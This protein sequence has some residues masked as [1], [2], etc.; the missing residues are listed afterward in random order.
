MHALQNNIPNTGSDAHARDRTA[1]QSAISQDL[2]SKLNV[3]EILGDRADAA[4][5]K[6]LA[7]LAYTRLLDIYRRH[8]Y[9]VGSLIRSLLIKMA[10]FYW[11]SDQPLRAEMCWWDVFD[12]RDPPDQAHGI[13]REVWESLAKSLSETSGVICEV[14]RAKL[15]GF[16]PSLNLETPFPPV[17]RMV[18]GNHGLSTTDSLFR[19]NPSSNITSS[20]NT[21]NASPGNVG[22]IEKTIQELP[23]MALDT[24]DIF[25]RTPLFLAAFLKHEVAG[26]ALVKRIATCSSKPPHIHINARDFSGQT[27]LGIAI[28]SRCSFKF[29]KAL[30]DNGAEVNPGLTEGPYTPLQAACITGDLEITNILLDSGADINHVYEDNP[31]PAALAQDY[32]HFNILQLIA[33]KTQSSL[34]SSPPFS[35]QSHSEVGNNI[36]ASVSSNIPSITGAII[37]NT[38]LTGNRIPSPSELF[39]SDWNEYL[40][41]PDGN[42]DMIS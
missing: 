14:L 12:L 6:D 1:A 10:V 7:E 5:E 27:V 18:R 39:S 29:V 33:E 9:P 35:N 23:D 26:H 8:P 19:I 28:L 24:R 31:T 16:F 13:E 4:G 36:I 20:S 41:V 3:V 30:I 38:Q 11:E 25:F 40:D 37:N 17:H 32:G 42:D 21:L 22:N 34:Q 2:L 15:T